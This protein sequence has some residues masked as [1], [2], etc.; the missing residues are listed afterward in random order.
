MR[1]IRL[2]TGASLFACGEQCIAIFV[3]ALKESISVSGC[4]T[5][6]AP[7]CVFD[8]LLVC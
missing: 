6:G 4:I 7:H 8:E 1:H 3:D 2:T 5:Q